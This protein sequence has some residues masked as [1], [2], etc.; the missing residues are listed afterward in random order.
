MY[1]EILIEY[2]IYLESIIYGSDQT[3]FS[4]L[5]NQYITQRSIIEILENLRYSFLISRE[6][7]KLLKYLHE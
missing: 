3:F 2:L 1:K 5:P 7:E 6:R 4:K